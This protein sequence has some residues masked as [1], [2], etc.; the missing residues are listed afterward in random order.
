MSPRLCI[1]CLERPATIPKIGQSGRRRSSYC[2]RCWQAMP[3][4]QRAQYGHLNPKRHQHTLETGRRKI[5]LG[6]HIMFAKTR[7]EALAIRA[8]IK[9]RREEFQKEQ[10]SVTLT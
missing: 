2:G 8:H 3:S 9:R 6:D 7:T 4:N 1:R 5:M 10:L